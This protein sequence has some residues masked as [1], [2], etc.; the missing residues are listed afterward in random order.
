MHQ[1]F[2]QAV[3]DGK[4]PLTTVRDCVDGTLLAIAAEESIRE[5]RIVEF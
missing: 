5:G 3:L 2:I 4:K 1:A